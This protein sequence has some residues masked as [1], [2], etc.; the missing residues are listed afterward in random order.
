MGWPKNKGLRLYY[1]RK[2]KSYLIVDTSE[3]TPSNCY[4][5]IGEVMIE[6]NPERPMLASS[7][8]SPGYLYSKCVRKSWSDMPKIWKD[9]FKD[10]LIGNPEDHKGLWKINQLPKPLLCIHCYKLIPANASRCMCKECLDLTVEE[11]ILNHGTQLS[12]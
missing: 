9:S 4:E 3:I 8:A 12:F 11:R 7:S 5:C 1:E 10:W 2:G 6:N